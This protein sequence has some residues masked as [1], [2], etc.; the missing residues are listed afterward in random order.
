MDNKTIKFLAICLLILLSIFI[1]VKFRDLTQIKV[2]KYPTADPSEV[3]LSEAVSRYKNGEISVVDLSALTTFSW[4]RLYVFGPYTELSKIDDV[5]GKS[6]RRSCFTTIDS[7]EGFA[8]LAFTNN[9][10][11]V[12]NCIE[13]P[14][15]TAD[16]ASLENH[17]SGFSI[18]EAR[19]ILDE[20]GNMIWVNDYK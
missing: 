12:V 2:K 15:D 17:E 11:Q 7:Y 14:R 20:R 8:L 19:F 9:E 16:F 18:Q 5:L 10:G 1:A 3:A 4:D 13:Y 6:W